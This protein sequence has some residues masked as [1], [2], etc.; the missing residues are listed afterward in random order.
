MIKRFNTFWNKLKDNVFYKNIAVVASGNITVKLIGVFLTPIITRLY[1]PVDYGVFNV[2]MSIVGITGSIATLRYAITIPIA[3]NEKVADNILKLCFFITFLLSLFWVFF[4]AIFGNKI[5]YYYEIPQL[6]T[7]IWLIPIVFLGKG[8][9]EA[10]NNWAIRFKKFKLITRTK[11][12]QSVSSSILKIGLGLLS[13]KPLGLFIGHIAQEAAGISSLL[14][15]LLK[16]K[17]NFFRSF[18]WIEIKQVAIR[19]KSFPL[20]QSWSQLLLATGGQ[21]PV[22]LLGLFYNAEVV[23][24]FGL[25]KGII[26]LPMD[27]IGQAVAQVYYAEISKIGKRNPDKIYKLSVSLIKK[28]FLI[29]LIPV[30]FLMVFGPWIFE[31]VFGEEWRDAGIYGRYLSIYVLMAF[32]SAPIANVFNVYERMD[33]QLKLNIIRVVYVATIFIVCHFINLTA[34]QTI[35]VFSI[36]MVFYFGYL[37]QSILRL[38]KMNRTEG[39][40]LYK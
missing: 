7:Y 37:T 3:K 12:S 17:P 38:V 40:E 22:L 30:A 34:K 35:F 23:G 20:I 26:H 31:F 25:A 24:V 15:S 1:T 14:S 39:N 9:Y 27:L 8:F 10:L 36:G 29:G 33:L 13:I 6:N 28:L 5:S 19:Y 11:V 4:I 18:S 21:L 2:F 16:S 32:I